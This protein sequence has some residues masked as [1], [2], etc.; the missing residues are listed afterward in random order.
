M[1]TS[2][3]RCKQLEDLAH[4]YQAALKNTF[5]ALRIALQPDTT[6]AV[7]AEMLKR[8]EGKGND[9]PSEDQDASQGPPAPPD[10]KKG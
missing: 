3:D 4:A 10:A 8:I 6:D 5:L 9:E 2:C 1:P 7:R